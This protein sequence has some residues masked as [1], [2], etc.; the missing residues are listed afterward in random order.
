MPGLDI[1]DLGKLE[2]QEVLVDGQQALGHLG[3]KYI[4]FKKNYLFSGK[5]FYLLHWEVLLELLLVHRVFRLLYHGHVV[6]EVP[7]V[8][9]A[10]EIVP[11]LLALKFTLID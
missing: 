1:F 5:L 11:V 3:K 2:P 7:E 6:A 9:L 8:K 4:V 10:G